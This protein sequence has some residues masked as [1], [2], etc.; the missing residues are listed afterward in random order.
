MSGPRDSPCRRAGA[1][2]LAHAQAPGDRPPLVVPVGVEI[3]QVDAVVTDKD[4]RHVTDLRAEDFEIVEDGK[5]RAIA[6]FRY[7][8]TGRAEAPSGPAPSVPAPAVPGFCRRPRS[9]AR[10]RSWW[11]TSR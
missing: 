8:S 11:T 4:G 1:A 9:R 3:V 7:V 5:K 2:D 10:W 6:N